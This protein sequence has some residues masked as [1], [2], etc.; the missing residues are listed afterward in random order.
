M[1]KTPEEYA[2]VKG[3]CCPA[4]GSFNTSGG[5]VDVDGGYAFQE[6]DCLECDS[7]WTDV[8]RLVGYINLEGGK[9]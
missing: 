8:Y 7:S 9:K 5:P 4:C 6:I 2:A 3:V 1:K